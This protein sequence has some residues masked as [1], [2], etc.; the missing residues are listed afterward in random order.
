MRVAII[1]SRGLSIESIERY[2]PADTDEI[3]SG[4]AR[5]IDMCARRY[6]LKNGIKLTE[7]LPDYNRY[8]RFAP[9][10]RNDLIISYADLVIAVWDGKSRG[11]AYVI[12]KCR[13]E[14]KPLHVL[15]CPAIDNSQN[16]V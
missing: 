3:V 9:L 16:K 12:D 4:G 6:A 15:S 2:L 10:R 13:R 7:F 5:G 8:G 11:T 1:G 14:D